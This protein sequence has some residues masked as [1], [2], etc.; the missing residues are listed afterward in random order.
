MFIHSFS[1]TVTVR[2]KK[3][4]KIGVYLESYHK[5]NPT[6]SHYNNTEQHSKK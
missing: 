1:K 3:M 4:W 2:N 5:A 6:P